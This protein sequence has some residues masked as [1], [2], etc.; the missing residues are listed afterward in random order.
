MTV[1]LQILAERNVTNII[2]FADVG[3]RFPLCAIS[4]YAEKVQHK[5][6]AASIGAKKNRIQSCDPM[7][8]P[9][10]KS[11]ELFLFGRVLF[12][13]FGYEFLDLFVFFVDVLGQYALAFSLPDQFFFLG[14]NDVDIQ[15][16]F[17]VS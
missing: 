3:S 13:D 9:L 14:I 4:F 16:A 11:M 12:Q 7:R 10:F 15:S 5:K 6:D 17:T 8:L 1:K 2:K